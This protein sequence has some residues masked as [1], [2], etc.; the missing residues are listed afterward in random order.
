MENSYRNVQ[1][2][3]WNT[4]EYNNYHG[5]PMVNTMVLHGTFME[6]C[7]NF[8]RIPWFPRYFHGIP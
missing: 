6:T 3:P 8:H 2:L 4:M 1:E 5:N 7:G